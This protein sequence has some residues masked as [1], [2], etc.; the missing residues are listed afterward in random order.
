MMKEKKVIYYSSGEQ[1]ETDQFGYELWEM[2]QKVK[3]RTGKSSVLFLCIGSDRSTGDSL[4]PLTGY[5]LKNE[6]MFTGNTNAIVVG[7]LTLPVHAVNLES[8]LQVIEEDFPEYIIIAIDASIGSRDSVGCITLAE[9]GL[10]PG[11]GVN[12]D[13]RKVGDISITG[14]VSWGSRL[15]PV[16]LQNIRLGMVMNM[17]DCIYQG[18]MKA[19]FFQCSSMH[20]IRQHEVQLEG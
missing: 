2:I 6:K 4:G 19:M 7:T 18:I 10:K 11:C 1:F 14:I 17:A 3:V 5:L 9:G 15:E 20:Q 12:K 16:L 13:L 8:V